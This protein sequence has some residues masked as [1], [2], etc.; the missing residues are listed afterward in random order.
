VL[1]PSWGVESVDDLSAM[2]LRQLCLHLLLNQA[3][4]LMGQHMQEEDDSG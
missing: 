2:D 1:D 4:V 3:Q